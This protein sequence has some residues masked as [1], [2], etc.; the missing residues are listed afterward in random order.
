MENLIANTD[1]LKGKL[2]ENVEAFKDQAL[3]SKRLATIKTDVEIPFET[4]EFTFH[5]T[6]EPLRQFYVRY[7]NELAGKQAFYPDQRAGGSRG[8]GLA[9]DTDGGG[10]PPLSGSTS[11]GQRDPGA[12]PG[13]AVGLFR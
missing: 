11:A 9:A 6:P 5:I 3:L 7:E 1:Q 10:S 13:S 12:R 2:K 8:P 4:E